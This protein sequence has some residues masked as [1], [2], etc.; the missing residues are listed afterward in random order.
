MCFGGGVKTPNIVYQ[1]PSDED[2]A[3]N[4]LA[5][6]E[7]ETRI[8]EQQTQ[9]DEQLQAQI[10][11]AN[12]ETA[13]LKDRLAKDSAA[14]QA[15]I[16]AQQT[17]AYAASAQVTDGDVEG[18]QTTAAVTKKK[19]EKSNLKINRAGLVASAGAGTNYGV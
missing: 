1:G 13:S 11:A 10:D 9:F 3:A 5:L 17:G 7:Y 19:K 12:L 8:T 14:A 4:E 6:K 16:A 2:L 18:S 15:A